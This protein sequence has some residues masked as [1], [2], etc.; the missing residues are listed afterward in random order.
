MTS[1]HP[2]RGVSQEGVT[3]ES[4]RPPTDL[5]VYLQQLPE[6]FSLVEKVQRLLD[7]ALET[8]ALSEDKPPLTAQIRKM[9]NPKPSR[10]FI[11]ITETI[12]GPDNIFQTNR[13]PLL[14]IL[15]LASNEETLSKEVTSQTKSK[16]S[17]FQKKTSFVGDVPSRKKVK[18]RLSW[19]PVLTINGKER[20]RSIRVPKE[21]VL[22]GANHR[23]RLGGE[24][25]VI[26]EESEDYIEG[27]LRTLLLLKAIE[28]EHERREYVD[29][30]WGKKE[31]EERLESE[32]VSP[33]GPFS[34]QYQGKGKVAEYFR[35]P[36][37]GEFWFR[38]DPEKEG[39]WELW[40]VAPTPRRRRRWTKMAA[41]QAAI[42]MA[43]LVWIGYRSPEML[44]KSG[45][46]VERDP[47]PYSV[48]SVDN[49][50]D[51][52]LWMGGLDVPSLEIVPLP[53]ERQ[54]P[55]RGRLFKFSGAHDYYLEAFSFLSRFDHI[56]DHYLGT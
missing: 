19:N 55:R 9:I 22:V 18:K 11:W 25:I 23:S 29:F 32:V 13:T 34:P 44:G 47:Y 43:F 54:K 21:I 1:P 35:M 45:V 31:R 6:T 26:Q 30:L 49:E 38:K 5:E 10:D 37:I 53:K 36:I 17:D 3:Y 2:K 24:G 14:E 12:F 39:L 56:R 48:S 7:C 8:Y 15:A 20:K 28:R 40:K 33:P 52:R 16:S 41:Q 4:K 50:Y 46:P 27:C 42:N 51:Q